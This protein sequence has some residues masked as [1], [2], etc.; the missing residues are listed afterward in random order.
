MKILTKLINIYDY[1]V[2]QILNINCGHGKPKDVNCE[3]CKEMQFTPFQS[4]QK[5]K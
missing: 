4:N 5:F 3:K 2:D 1:F